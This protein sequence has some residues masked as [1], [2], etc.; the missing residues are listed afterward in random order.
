MILV[1][2]IAFPVC[3]DIL[4]T[5]VPSYD[6]QSLDFD[7][8][9]F[10]EDPPGVCAEFS[11]AMVFG[12][13][14]NNGWKRFVPYGSA[15]SVENPRGVYELVNTIISHIGSGGYGMTFDDYSTRLNINALSRMMDPSADFKSNFSSE[16]EDVEITWDL[17]KSSLMR[18]GPG[19]LCVLYDFEYY[20]NQ[21]TI[22][23][24]Q[25]HVMVTVGFKENFSQFGVPANWVLLKSTWDNGD[26]GQD[27]LWIN[28]D[29]IDRFENY[30]GYLHFYEGGSPSSFNDNT[31]DEHEDDDYRTEAL[32]I[33]SPFNASMSC[34]DYDWFEISLDRGDK[35][36]ALIS[37]VNSNGNLDLY[38]YDFL[39]RELANSES[40][41][42]GEQVNHVA[43]L[44]GN[45]YILVKGRDFD[46]NTYTISILKTR[47]TYTIS[48]YVRASG[49]AGIN[50]VTVTFN[51][52]GG[53]A[54]TDS[55]GYY[56][57]TVSY[58]WSG[59]A[60]P[61]LSGYTFTPTSLTYVNVT[62]NKSEQNYTG[63]LPADPKIS[64]YVRTS[65]GI[66]M[67]GVT[68]AFSDGG[69]TATT[70][71]SGYYSG[72]VS[73]GWS[74]SVTP[75]F[76]GYTFMPTSLNYINV[77]TSQSSQDYTGTPL[78]GGLTVTL[79][80]AAAASTGAQWN[81][82]RGPWQNSGAALTGLSVGPHTVTYKAVTGWI[83]PPS[84]TVSVISGQ[85][86]LITRAYTE[87]ITRKW[88]SV[89]AQFQVNNYTSNTQ[90][91]PSVAGLSGGG[92]VATWQSY[93]QDGSNY[94]IYGQRYSCG[95]GICRDEL[96]TSFGEPHG[97]WH[98]D[99]EG[100]PHIKFRRWS[101]LNTIDPDLMIAVDIDD[102]GWDELAAAFSGYGLYIYDP[103]TLW[104][105]INTVI[106]ENMIRMN[107]GIACDFGA[108]YGLWYWTQTGGWQPWKTADPHQLLAMDIDNDGTEELV[109]SFVSDGLYWRY[110]TGPWM[111]INA[112]IPEN[113]IRLNNGIA[114]DFGA[115]YGLWYWTEIGGW[116]SWNTVDPDQ[117][118]AVD[119]DSDGTEE[120]VASFVSHG[121]YWRYETGPWMP[122]NAVIPENMIRLNNGI[123]C[124]FGA[125]FGLWT[126]TQT[127]DWVRRNHVD[128]VQTAAM[129]I[130]ND[131][132]QELVACFMAYGLYSQH[133]SGSWTQLNDICP[134]NMIP[135]DLFP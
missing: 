96:I 122:I 79:L 115:S 100:L 128:P 37:F 75:R 123:A 88:G 69:G 50:G 109:A 62:T 67:N 74:G 59:S 12:Y 20:D 130:D 24:T 129:D 98:Y 29:D 73:Y 80:P 86:T 17:I 121:L 107:N 25:N 48:G 14:D 104:T 113:M 112:V 13:H 103:I 85:N 81:V 5:T 131:G 16:V 110:E 65:E 61:S 66:G 132:W 35:I 84:E 135:I 102:D 105:P 49:G 26:E 64:G 101:P 39:G 68:V 52:G 87:Q 31:D 125:S 41:L 2:G 53:S 30:L 51:N 72:T 18:N 93:G 9:G 119:V 95:D 38:L 58:G 127:G 15:S 99:Q 133:E 28:W 7:L 97:L 90:T 27:P 32:Q 126:W 45:Y 94:G 124:D 76:S 19:N 116:Q 134:E 34:N 43:S 47:A 60:T 89:G 118:L 33:S 56:T 70:S 78:S 1:I 21:G 82:D 11:I 55:S 111:P 3:A 44:A 120:L 10:N 117:L 57:A 63:R 23:Q 4:Y 40:N 46:Q 6:Q 114:C 22:G 83:A 42:N 8:D 92:F 91:G 54:T 71:G 106:P 36:D 77:T 108:S